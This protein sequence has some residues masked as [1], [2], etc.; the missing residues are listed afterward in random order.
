[1]ANEIH[2]YPL[3]IFTIGDNDYLDVDYF[4]GVGYDSAKILGL[5]LKNTLKSGMYSM[6]AN[7]SVVGGTTAELD[8]MDGAYIGS[9]SVPANTFQVG[10]SFRLSVCGYISAHNND[11]LT[12][13]IKSGMTIISASAPITMPSI[14]F[15]VFELTCVFTIRAIGGQ[16]AASVVT[17]SEFTWN[18]AA[19][20]TYEGQNWIAVNSSNFDTTIPNTLQ[21]TAEWSSSHPSNSIQ[22]MVAN[23]EKI[24]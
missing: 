5:S 16:M 21:L 10:D 9:L 2:N 15:E 3:E 12:I 13:R 1:M 17:N 14:G 4:N 20:N 19:A 8:F 24:Y 23:L 22:S 11:T 6:I 18:K 7:S